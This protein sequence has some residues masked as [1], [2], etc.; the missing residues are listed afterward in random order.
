MNI[1][2]HLQKIGDRH[3]PMSSRLL[4]GSAR[5]GSGRGGLERSAV[6]ND[7]NKVGNRTE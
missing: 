2:G 7:R 6:M 4:C 3:T 1:G 5:Q